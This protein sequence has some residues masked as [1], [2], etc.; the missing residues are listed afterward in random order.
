MAVTYVDSI[1]DSSGTGS[2]N[3]YSMTLPTNASGD[4]MLL[5]VAWNNAGANQTTPSG[6]T[7]LGSTTGG[8]GS[9]RGFLFGKVST[10][11]EASVTIALSSGFLSFAAACAVFAGADSDLSNVAFNQSTGSGDFDWP[12]MTTTAAASASVRLG[13][14]RQGTFPT[15]HGDADYTTAETLTNNSNRGAVGIY[16]DLDVGDS[17]TA[18]GTLTESN[19]SFTSYGLWDV[20]LLSAEAPPVEVT[21]P[22]PALGEGVGFDLSIT[23]NTLTITLPTPSLGES[24]GFDLVITTEAL[25][26]V[27]PA[28]V[29]GEGVG[30]SLNITYGSLFGLAGEVFALESGAEVFPIK[31]VAEVFPLI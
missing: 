2:I 30:Y 9:H 10:G 15:P 19:G 16:Y 17:G 24:V 18:T 29:L 31:V 3:S 14:A 8:V 5:T 28:P 6:W 25:S 4:V 22:A 13:T 7:L 12:S 21:L 23:Y 1:T 11:N 20:E 27:L 26:I